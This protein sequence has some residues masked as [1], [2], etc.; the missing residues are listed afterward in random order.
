MNASFLDTCQNYTGCEI[1]VFDII[2]RNTKER[3]NINNYAFNKNILFYFY[4]YLYRNCYKSVTF[5]H[6]HLFVN[7]HRKSLI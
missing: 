6:N 7:E 4:K 1:F 2:F 3:I 5:W